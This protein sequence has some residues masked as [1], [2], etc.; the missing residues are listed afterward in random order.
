MTVHR[1]LSTFKELNR[2]AICPGPTMT[3]M[4]ERNADEQTRR[5]RIAL[6]PKGRWLTP[7]DHGRVTVFLRSEAA[8]ALC[9]L[10]IDV[11]TRLLNRDRIGG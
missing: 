11:E 8:D 1:G 5:E 2:D 6:V 3:P 9:G 4:Y 7:E 10:A